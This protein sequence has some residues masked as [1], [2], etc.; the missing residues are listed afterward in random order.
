MISG[1]LGLLARKP[2][3]SA[4][5]GLD[6]GVEHRLVLGPGAAK[7]H[8]GA[9]MHGHQSTRVVPAHRRRL[10]QQRIVAGQVKNA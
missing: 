1:I 5:I 6:D 3:G 7:R 8:G 2:L 10:G 4:G 9:R